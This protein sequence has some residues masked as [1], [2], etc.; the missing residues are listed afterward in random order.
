MLEESRRPTADDIEQ[1]YR[2]G[3]SKVKGLGYFLSESI[4]SAY[5]DGSVIRHKLKKGTKYFAF[6]TGGYTGSWGPE[7]R[8]AML[9]QKEIVLNAQDTENLLSAV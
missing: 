5:Q 9:H 3:I 1:D 7:G 8:L 2:L 6:D 4:G